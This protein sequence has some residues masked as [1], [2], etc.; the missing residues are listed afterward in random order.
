MLVVRVGDRMKKKI[1]KIIFIMLPVF[2]II[3]ILFIPFF[4]PLQNNM[5]AW[6]LFC[7]YLLNVIFFLSLFNNKAKHTKMTDSEK[8]NLNVTKEILQERNRWF[9]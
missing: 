3:G 4:K 9:M 6:I 7:I 5:I 8:D 2:Y 1:A